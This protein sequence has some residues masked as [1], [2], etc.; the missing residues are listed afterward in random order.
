MSFLQ[1]FLALN[2]TSFVVLNSRDRAL[3]HSQRPKRG[4]KIDAQLS[5]FDDLQGVWK[6]G[7]TLS[8]MFDISSQSRLKLRRN[9]R[10]KTVEI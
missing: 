1:F 7:Q 3:P 6:C 4:W 8:W 10:D 5:I 9:R 2:I